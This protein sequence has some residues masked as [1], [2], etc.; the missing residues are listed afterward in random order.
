V[1]TGLATQESVPAAFAL[2]A[3]SPDDPWQVCLAAAGLGGDSD[4]VAAMA[5]AVAGALHGTAGFPSGAVDLVTAV[6]DLDLAP[7]AARLLELRDAP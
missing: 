3:L 2:V 7:L 5:G 6:N 4:T 1:G